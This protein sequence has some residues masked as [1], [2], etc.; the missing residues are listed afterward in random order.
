LKKLTEA[1]A[2]RL[3][4]T[5]RKVNSSDAAYQHMLDTIADDIEERFRNRTF[6]TQSRMVTGIARFVRQWN[7]S[8]AERQRPDGARRTP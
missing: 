3:V 7:P 8:N 4:E 1:Q 6:D 5:I 2:R